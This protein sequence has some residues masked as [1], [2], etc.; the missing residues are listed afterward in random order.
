MVS[1]I[2]LYTFSNRDESGIVMRLDFIVIDR[3]VS[4]S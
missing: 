4:D 2:Y 1:F 3:T